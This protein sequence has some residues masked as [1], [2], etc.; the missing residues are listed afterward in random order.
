MKLNKIYKSSLLVAAMMVILISCSDEL[1]VLVPYPTDITFNDLNVDRFSFKIPESPFEVGDSDTGIITVNVVNKGNGDFSGF[2][3]SNKNWRSYPWSLSPDF[4]PAGGL[5]VVDRKKAID[6]TVFSVFTS[7]P[8]RTENFLVANTQDD[9]AYINLKTPSVVEHVLVANTT[10]NYLTAGNGSVYSGTFD[11][12]TQ[13]YKIDGKKI[14]NMKIPNPS[15]DMYGRFFLPGPDNNN[16][17]RLSSHE[18]I[19]KRKKGKIAADIARSQGATQGQVVADSTAAA[20]AYVTGY[21]KLTVE[22][23]KNGAGTSSLDYY[24]AVRPNV[25]P[26]NPAHDKIIGDWFKVDLTSLGEVDKILFKMSSSYV[27]AN[28]EMR[29]LPNFCLDGIRLRNH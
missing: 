9:E 6:S 20:K 27:D 2:A 8:N 23:F 1:E 24:L 16:L 10:Y 5:S 17:L 21:L 12:E 13:Q 14:R 19:E 22:G 4:E 25:D 28:G 7:S 15:I 11:N 26:E 29:Y 18:I 3:I